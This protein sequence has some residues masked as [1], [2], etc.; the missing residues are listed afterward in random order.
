MRVEKRPSEIKDIL[1]V[2][3]S[4]KQ[5]ITPLILGK[6]GI[7][8]SEIVQQL[9]EEQGRVLIDLRLSQLDSVDLRGFPSD[10]NGKTTKWLPSNFMPFKGSQYD[11]QKGILFLDEVNRSD[12]AMKQ[13]IFQL[14]YNRKVGDNEICDDWY[15]VCAGNL[16]IEDDNDVIEF[17]AAL[18]NRFATLYMDITVDEW[19]TWAVDNKVNSFITSFI[20]KYPQYL[21]YKV[22]DEERKYIT[23]R[24][25]TIFSKI[26]ENNRKM[27]IKETSLLL[28]DSMIDG[29]LPKFVQH[30]NDTMTFSADDIINRYPEIKG[31]LKKMKKNRDKI[32]ELVQELELKM[33]DIMSCDVKKGNV[34]D[35]LADYPSHDHLW[36]FLNNTATEEDKRFIEFFETRHPKRAKELEDAYLK[37]ITDMVEEITAAIPKNIPTEKDIKAMI[38]DIKANNVRG[39]GK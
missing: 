25:W 33:D 12:N 8:K 27:G 31:Q 32:Y 36:A 34:S 21:Y 23:P 30:V 1:R 14:I 20:K 29:I 13:A 39:G 4:G 18:K 10:S 17:D 28:G 7:G 37:N 15:I 26:L 19:L 11:G 9:A 5:E 35:F 38:E 16:G 6:S 24:S 2:L 22:E 3:L